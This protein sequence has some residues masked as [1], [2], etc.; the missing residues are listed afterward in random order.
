MDTPFTHLKSETSQQ[1][2]GRIGGISANTLGMDSTPS[3]PG[4]CSHMGTPRPKACRQKEFEHSYMRR[5]LSP[6]PR[7]AATNYQ[8]QR[9]LKEKKFSLA[10][11]RTF[12]TS[13]GL[14]PP[15]GS[16]GQS[17]PGLRTSR[18]FW[19]PLAFLVD[20][21]SLYFC[22]HCHL[23]PPPFLT[24]PMTRGSC[25]A[26]DRTHG[27]VETMLDHEPAEPPG[28]ASGLCL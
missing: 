5:H 4:H 14:V 13:A 22:L 17:V 18:G 19:Q 10:P 26:M 23:P 25:L 24:T 7:A 21:T 15:R 11:I 2:V 6:L 28:N 12:T 9:G 1:V 16:Q 3:A 27:T 8:R 20:A